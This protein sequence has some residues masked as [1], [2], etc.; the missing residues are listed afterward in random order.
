M[1]GHHLIHNVAHPLFAHFLTQDVGQSNIQE[2]N[3]LPTDENLYS[4]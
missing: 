3:K 1:S 2:V 4:L